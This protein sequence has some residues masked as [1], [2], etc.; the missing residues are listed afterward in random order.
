MS[1]T[2]KELRFDSDKAMD[3]FA[4]N[5]A[6]TLGPVELKEMLEEEGLSEQIKVTALFAPEPHK[7]LDLIK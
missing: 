3:F 1:E 5:L 2:I 4:K 7:C 6:Y